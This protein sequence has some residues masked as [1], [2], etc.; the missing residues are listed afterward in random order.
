MNMKTNRKRIVA[1]VLFVAVT[2]FLIWNRREVILSIHSSQVLSGQKVV[3]IDPGHG[4]KDAGKIAINGALEKDI[5]LDI[6]L[7]VKKLLENQNVYVKMTR[8]DDVGFYPKTGKNKKLR[9]M[10]ERVSFMNQAMPDLVVSIHQN[11][12]SDSQVAG[13]QTFFAEGKEESERAAKLMQAQFWE[14]DENNHRAAKANDS[15]Y[16]LKHVQYP[17]VIAE[18]GFLSNAV[19]AE[20]LCDKQYQRQIAWAIHL[21]IMQYL[22]G[23][24]MHEVDENSN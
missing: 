23:G 5:N 17:I 22:N 24:Q 8:V 18:C 12:F 14:I 2:G 21:G 7:Q 1:I 6:A 11:S 16:L 9:D 4:S 10:K 3:V 15:Y 20:K 19:D 13:A